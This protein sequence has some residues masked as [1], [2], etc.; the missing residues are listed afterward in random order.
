LQALAARAAAGVAAVGCLDAFKGEVYAGFFRGG[1]PPVPVADEIVAPASAVVARMASLFAGEPIHLFGEAPSRWPELV[2]PG[3]ASDERPPDPVEV[4][5]RAAPRL[6]RGE[7]D[8]LAAAAP[9]YI[10][11]SEAE[12]LKRD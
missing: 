9:R 5:R 12:L 7:R 11:P 4:A 8:D 6:P 2:L 1:D 10:R 3:A